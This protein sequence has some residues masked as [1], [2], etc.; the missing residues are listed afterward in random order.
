MD[1]LPLSVAII[2]YN[3]EDI[4]GRALEAVRDI[5]S[6]IIVVDSHSTDRTREIAQAHGAKVYT[7][8]WKGYAQ[9]KNSAL[10]K[11]TQEWV[12][13]LDADE[14]VSEELKRSIKE[15]LKDPQ[16]DGYMINR[17]TYYL[18]GFLEHVWQPEWRLRLV[19]RSADPVWKGDI[20]EV[21]LI[22]GRTRKLKG[23]LYHFPYRGLKNQALKGVEFAQ[24]DAKEKFKAGKKVSFTRDI[25]LRPLWTFFKEFFLRKGFLEGRRG[26]ILSLMAS[27]YTFL[28]YSFLYELKLKADIG[29]RLW[30]REER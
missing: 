29:D 15:E 3:E 4:I 21:L 25:L 22:K 19:R 24:I 28:K 7:E 18:G 6:E 17:K 14:I 12:L 11:C 20:H 26:L 9:Q 5:A 23:D 2:T 10:E 1:K 27:Y 8:D 13:F 16:A 30:R